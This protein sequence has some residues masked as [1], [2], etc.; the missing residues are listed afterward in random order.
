VLHPWWQAPPPWY[1][2]RAFF[3]ALGLILLLA[4]SGLAGWWLRQRPATGGQKPSVEQARRRA[5]VAMGAGTF[6]SWLAVLGA[7]LA[8]GMAD[9]AHPTAAQTVLAVAAGVTFL[10]APLL[11]SFVAL[12]VLRSAGARLAVTKSTDAHVHLDEGVEEARMHCQQTLINEGCKRIT[13]DPSGMITARRRTTGQLTATPMFVWVRSENGGAVV[14]VRSRATAQ[15]V[16][17]VVHHPS[18]LLVERFVEDLGRLAHVVPAA[19]TA[20]T[21]NGHGN[22]HGNG[23]GHGHGTATS[24]SV[25]SPP[26]QPPVSE[27]P[28]P[29][30][31]LSGMAVASLVL[32]VAWLFWLGSLLAVVFGHVALGQ[33]RRTRRRGRGLAL[34]GTII[35]WLSLAVFVAAAVAVKI[36]NLHA[37]D[38]KAPAVIVRD[39]TGASARALSLHMSGTTSNGGTPVGVDLVLGPGSAAGTLTEGSATIRLVLAGGTLFVDANAAFWQQQGQSSDLADHWVS[40][41]ATDAGLGA[42]TDTAQVFG[43]L[44]MKA[45][46]TKAPVTTVDGRQV[47]PVSDSQGTVLYVADTGPPYIVRILRTAAAAQGAGQIDFDQYGTAHVPGPPTGAVPLPS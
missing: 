15:S 14:D 25:V 43:H 8:G 2:A 46:L 27:G 6:G 17:S 32:A 18:D 45:P 11:W 34:A 29:R 33:I 5:L 4:A 13:A 16:A 23:N 41:S 3:L 42:L 19:P 35:G 44:A 36:D 39:A 38:R 22:G 20:G 26:A 9:A 12:Q 37:E 1:R 10:V 24:G 21:G 7:L 31:P 28:G 30:P 47:V 40:M